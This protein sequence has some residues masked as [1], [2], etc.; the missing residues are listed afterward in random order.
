MSIE[1]RDDPEQARVNYRW[2]VFFSV[3]FPVSAVWIVY[4]AIATDKLWLKTFLA[5]AAG[6]LALLTERA[7][8]E[9]KFWRGKQ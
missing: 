8:K 7:I 9:A 5:L 6:Y 4:A 1:F 2:S 3:L